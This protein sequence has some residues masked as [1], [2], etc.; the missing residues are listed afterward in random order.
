MTI[1][2]SSRSGRSSTGTLA[3]L[4]GTIAMVAGC[5]GDSTRPAPPPPPP[6][7]P[8][9]VWHDVAG[10]S[11]TMPG[12]SEGYVCF[13][14]HVTS[15][16]YLTGF[17][18][19]SPSSAQKEVLITVSD[20]PVT[21]GSFACSAGSLNTHL[22]YA[23]SGPT[24]PI[25][26]PAGFGVHVSAGQYVLLNI[27]ADNGADTS[28]TASTSVEARIGTAADVTTPIDM[29]MA[30]TFLI[31]IPADGL[32]HTATGS[33]N[34]EADN[35]LLAFLPLM[36][37][38]GKHQTVSITAGPT[39]QV[40]FDQ[41]FDLLHDNYTQAATPI[42]IAMGNHLTTQCSFMNTGATTLNYGE[43]SQNESCLAAIYRYPTA[44]AGSLYDCAQGLASFDVKRE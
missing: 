27:H 8:P 5:G 10:R 11:W 29:Q 24:G 26:F 12:Q 42:A 2:G 19:A 37:S 36:R 23:A 7:P 18:L 40:I 21:E 34:A 30:G 41:D 9:D 44:A 14:V 32:L 17:R 15:D 16:E 6:P 28:V 25:E 38:A 1:G 4:L 43:S 22:I 13:G 20:T 39:T 33:C 3:L 35:H 31:N